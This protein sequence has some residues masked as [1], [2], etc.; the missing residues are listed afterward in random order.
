MMVDHN[1]IAQLLGQYSRAVN[2]FV[3]PGVFGYSLEINN[4]I[5][6]PEKARTEVLEIFGQEGRK[7]SLDLTID[8]QKIGEYIQKEFKKINIKVELNF[9]S[10]QDLIEKIKKRTSEMYILG[11]QSESGDAG[12]ILN[13]LFLENA[14]LNSIFLPRSESSKEITKLIKLSNQELKPKKRLEILQNI[15]KTLVDRE[16]VGIPLFEGARIYAVQS[17]VNFKPRVDGMIVLREINYK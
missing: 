16:V 15:M 8:Y 12:D 13:S 4:Q 10:P 7:T 9:L 2:Q 1:M 5:Y 14:Q 11:W 3:S 6:N 17:K